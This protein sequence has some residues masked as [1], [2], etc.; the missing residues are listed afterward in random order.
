MGFSL[1]GIFKKLSPKGLGQSIA[2]DLGTAN[3]LFYLLGEGVVLN[4]PSYVAYDKNKKEIL[5]GQRAKELWGRTGGD[6]EVARPLKDGVIT[7]SETTCLMLKTF[8]RMVMAQRQIV[9][10]RFLVGISSGI[11]N[12]E[13]KAVI[14]TA[15]MCGARSVDL[16]EEPMAA[17]IGCGL[18]VDD[19][20]GMMVVDVGGGTTEVAIIS[21]GAIAHKESVR[22]GGDKIDQ[23]IA[24]YIRQKHG[25]G[26]GLIDAERIKMEIGAAYPSEDS[27]VINT[28]VNGLDLYSGRLEEITITQKEIVEAIKEPVDAMLNAIRATL[29]KCSPELIRDIAERGLTLTGGG[30]LLTGL[31]ELIEQRLNIEVSIPREPLLSVV[32]GLGTIL[33][34][35][36]QYKKLFVN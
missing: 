32:M 8:S 13:K 31:G 3:V 17:A 20:R 7:D 6:M 34:N 23:A 18:P 1:K 5:V 35:I 15:H 33:E 11:T 25:V 16:V 21:M 30:A 36:D 4:E 14:E 26:I 9:G 2:I 28:T 10:P 29:D 27:A 12:V 22:A 19:S 24:D